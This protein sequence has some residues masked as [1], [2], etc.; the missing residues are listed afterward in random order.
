VRLSC[1]WQL[2]NLLRVPRGD[3][4]ERKRTR[5]MPVKMR[6]AGESAARRK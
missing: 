5:V 3:V 6:K 1:G 2:S 4:F